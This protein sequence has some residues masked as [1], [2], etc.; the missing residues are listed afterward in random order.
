MA[1]KEQ[2]SSS[3]LAVA[4]VLVAP[5]G[6]HSPSIGTDED[7]EK[8][9]KAAATAAECLVKAAVKQCNERGARMAEASKT[10]EVSASRIPESRLNSSSLPASLGML[11]ELASSREG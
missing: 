4:N 10:G 3:T 2:A 9:S 5:T 11:P 8:I 1:R 7:R 6:I